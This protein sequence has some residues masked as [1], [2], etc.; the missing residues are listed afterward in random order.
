LNPSRDGDSTTALGSLVQWLTTPSLIF[1]NIQSKPP[2]TQLEAIASHPV[3]G[4]WGE[5]TNPRLITTS[6][7]AVVESDKVPPQPPLLQTE[8][9]QF[10]QLLLSRLVL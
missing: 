10:P 3:A 9:S 5:E 6:F 7:L 8:Q 2:L 1:P 4:Y